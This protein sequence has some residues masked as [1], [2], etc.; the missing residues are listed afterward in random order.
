MGLFFNRPEG[1]KELSDA[2]KAWA[3]SVGDHN[4]MVELKRSLRADNTPR[5][6]LILS[7]FERFG[8]QTNAFPGFFR[9]AVEHGARGC[10]ALIIECLYE[11]KRHDLA[12]EILPMAARA[13]DRASWDALLSW[14]RKDK[15]CQDGAIAVAAAEGSEELLKEVLVDAVNE[16]KEHIFLAALR[17]ASRHSFARTRFVAGWKNLFNEGQSLLND[18]FYD[19]AIVG[20]FI[21][22]ERLRAA[23][24][25]INHGNARTLAQA[26]GAYRI[27]VVKYLVR[28]GTDLKKHGSII[29]ADICRKYPETELSRYL[30]SFFGG[31]YEKQVK[32]EERKRQESRRFACIDGDMLEERKHLSSGGELTLL[33]NFRTRQQYVLTRVQHAAAAEV[34]PFSDIDPEVLRAAAERF[35]SLGGDE[36]MADAARN[37]RPRLDFKD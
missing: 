10:A 4:A 5:V 15:F 36:K 37:G 18:A 2:D 31:V 22:A 14:N 11:R 32:E 3:R 1:W 13:Q 17:V 34:V 21:P 30:D 9:D 35:V 6:R 24:A 28:K 19:A 26:A 25:D 8:L 27:E 33:F 20:D 29:A 16:R 23:G 7:N 12:R